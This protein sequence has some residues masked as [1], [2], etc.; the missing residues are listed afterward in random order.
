MRRRPERTRA[1]AA[2]AGTAAAGA[3]SPRR[4]RRR[5]RRR[6]AAAACAGAR[7]VRR[8]SRRRRDPRRA[9][10]SGAY[11]IQLG[12][13]KSSADAANR[14]WA[15]LDKEYP[16]LLAGLSPTVSPKKSLGGTLYRLQVVG[17]HAKS[18]RARFARS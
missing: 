9:A 5:P 14:R 2:P 15:H 17:P 12:A 6:R 3:G 4:P 7:D 13:F 18:T 16:K 10:K 8:R 11:G 1:G